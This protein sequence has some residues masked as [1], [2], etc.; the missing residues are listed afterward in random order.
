MK[1]SRF[2]GKFHLLLL[3][4]AGRT[5]INV[6]HAITNMNS[7]RSLILKT[8]LFRLPLEANAKNTSEALF[9]NVFPRSYSMYSPRFIEP[10]FRLEDQ[11]KLKES[12]EFAERQFTPVK[13]ALTNQTSSIFYDPIVRKFTNYVM[14]TGQRALARDLVNETFECIKHTQ[15]KKK[16]QAETDEE[17]EKIETNP[18]VIIHKAVENCRPVL[19]LTPIKRGGIKY[20][21]PVPLTEKRS[22]FIAMRWLVEA[23]RDKGRTVKFAEK[24]ARELIEASMNEGRIVKKKQDLHRQCEANRAYAHYRWS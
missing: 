12:G 4:S 8:S 5:A 7:I 24:L 17:K 10:T 18:V 20:Q 11:E 9:K 3:T 15:L 19:Q 21:V 2:K 23:G 13:A 6:T 22:Y 16:H 1:G 14:I